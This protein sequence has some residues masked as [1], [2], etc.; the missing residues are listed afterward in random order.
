MRHIWNFPSCFALYKKVRAER[1][2]DEREILQ[3]TLS[4]TRGISSKHFAQTKIVTAIYSTTLTWRK[5][6]EKYMDVVQK[7]Y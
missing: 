4:R 6:Y 1:E 3:T 7:Q 5:M 2:D